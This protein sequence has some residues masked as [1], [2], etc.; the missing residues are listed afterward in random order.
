MLIDIWGRLDRP[1]SVFY[2][3]TWTGV[4]GREPTGREQHV[5][6]TVRTRAT[7]PLR[8]WNRPL[9][10]AGR[11]AASRPTMRRGR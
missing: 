2:D 9:R 10:R 7:R 6:E 11:S 3:I 8:R 1:D 5:F 4:V